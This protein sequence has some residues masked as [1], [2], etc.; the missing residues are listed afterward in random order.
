MV[1]NSDTAVMSLCSF[2]FTPPGF[3]V[4][5]LDLK[6]KS[7]SGVVSTLFAINNKIVKLKTLDG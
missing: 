1:L 4:I 7:E 3:G 6:T 2:L 5:K